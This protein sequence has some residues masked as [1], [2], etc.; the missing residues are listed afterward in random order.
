MNLQLPIYEP[1]AQPKQAQFISLDV[2]YVVFHRNGQQM[3]MFT[4][5][6]DTG[7][8]SWSNVHSV[9]TSGNAVHVPVDALTAMSIFGL[10]AEDMGFSEAEMALLNIIKGR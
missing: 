6:F 3:K 4:S 1:P 7:Y 8:K 9:A 10:T 5:W 2:I